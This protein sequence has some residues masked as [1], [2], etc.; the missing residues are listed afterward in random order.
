MSN[1]KSSTPALT[2][3]LNAENPLFKSKI[4]KY[5]N[6]MGIVRDPTA[7]SLL[8]K[9]AK[10]LKT[11]ET[12]QVNEKQSKNVDPELKKILQDM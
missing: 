5:L 6:K 10:L 11:L 7:L 2:K 9:T 1:Q 8:R 12:N 4:V 3:S